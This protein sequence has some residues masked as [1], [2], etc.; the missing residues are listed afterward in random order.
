MFAPS[1][2]LQI[3]GCSPLISFP[4]NIRLAGVG[5]RLGFV[6]ADLVALVVSGYSSAV[7]L[8]GIAALAAVSTVPLAAYC[9]AFAFPSR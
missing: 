5:I 4:G 9:Q 3:C 8:A 7:A 6:L 1:H 2:R